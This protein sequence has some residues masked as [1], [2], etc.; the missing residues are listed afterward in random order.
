MTNL[1]QFRSTA[2]E[3]SLGIIFNMLSTLYAN[4]ERSV[5]REYI[6]N[7]IDSHQIAGTKRPV[8]VTLPT[9]ASPNL[10][11]RDF[12]TGLSLDDL[13]H[14]FFGF[15]R[16]TK[17]DSDEQIGALGIGAKSAF[18]LSKAWTVTN[19]HAGKKYV[20]A[21]VNDASGPMQSVI[22]NG[23]DTDEPSGITVSVPIE[24]A[25]MGHSWDD[26]A[27]ELLRWFPKGGVTVHG[28][29][30]VS[31]WSDT[32]TVYGPLVLDND[33]SRPYYHR[34][35]FR[36]A[37]CGVAYVV[38]SENTDKVRQDALN[39]ID[40]ILV[41]VEGADRYATAKNLAQVVRSQPAAKDSDDERIARQV[42]AHRSVLKAMVETALRGVILV[43]PGSIDF[44]PSRESVQG[45]VRTLEAITANVNAV[46]RKFADE[47]AAYRTLLPSDRI[48]KTGELSKHV[49]GR[50]ST[51]LLDALGVHDVDT[52]VTRRK[53]RY[54]L[55][56][57]VNH[58]TGIKGS[59]LVHD[60]NGI[61][62]LYKRGIL[63][64][65]TGQN[66]YTMDGEPSIPGFGDLTVLFR[67]T[68]ERLPNALT[69]EDYKALASSIAP[70]SE[71]SYGRGGDATTYSVFTMSHD[72]A[73]WD[74]QRTSSEMTFDEI[75]DEYAGSDIP[76]YVVDSAI[77]GAT[78]GAAGGLD[79]V[80]I[81]RGR[82]NFDTFA[83]VLEIDIQNNDAL[84][85]NTTVANITRMAALL[86]QRTDSEVRDM[87][88][89]KDLSQSVYA[90]LR[91]VLR[92]NYGSLVTDDHRA[93]K[94]VASYE[95]GKVL[96]NSDER[97]N[98]SVSELAHLV[99]SSYE[100][101][102]HKGL[103]P[104]SLTAMLKESQSNPWPLLE[105]VRGDATQLRHAAVYLAA[106]G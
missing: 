60:M 2:D 41:E 12:G 97:L 25:H 50:S 34:V 42:S 8:E 103:V 58:L 78:R 89:Y 80:V 104:A 27:R 71:D 44:M 84:A 46:V 43:E 13:K 48:A 26:T 67:S 76:V 96:L 3:K 70:K 93:R 38:D 66:I 106:V 47:I 14:V 74:A 95:A 28:L 31:H 45:T 33:D 24:R 77:N 73:T 56:T 64:R 19:I 23:A 81:A 72:P 15:A 55:H 30:D 20:V 91:E 49:M 21:S 7:A 9:P 52:P 68:D 35:D 32:S 22:V 29:D 69:R 53:D 87:L 61:A 62:S 85:E 39:A 1:E 16:S 51:N 17:T 57:L 83:K 6:A 102:Q 101:K 92:S 99:K 86:G 63:E 54:S 98:K 37:M 36:V 65:L 75:I 88:T 90:T 4:P 11:I 18:A 94:T 100:S 105:S 40:K 82:R 59:V 5:M 10:V 79:G